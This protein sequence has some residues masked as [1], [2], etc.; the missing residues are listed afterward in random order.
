MSGTAQP[1]A[2]FSRYDHVQCPYTARHAIRA[3]G[4]EK[5]VHESRSKSIQRTPSSEDTSRVGRSIRPTRARRPSDAS[6]D[7]TD[8]RLRNDNAEQQRGLSELR[9]PTTLHAP[10][11]RCRAWFGRIAPLCKQLG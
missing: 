11:V 9:S 2:Q 8:A 7:P 10:A 4:V 5:S 6:V 3:D 1:M